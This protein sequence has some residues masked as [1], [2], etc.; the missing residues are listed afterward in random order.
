MCE[1]ELCP[2]FYSLL[3]SGRATR[4]DQIDNICVLSGVDS[5]PLVA[6][7]ISIIDLGSMKCVKGNFFLSFISLLSSGRATRSDQI[8]NIR[9]VLSGVDSIPLV[10]SAISIISF[11]SM[12]C[13]ISNR[14][15][16][17]NSLP[18]DSA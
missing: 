15:L 10:A 5:I 6:S 11:G 8:D 2:L 1:R 3:S 16:L 9:C 4:S 7:V 14:L 18:S 12:K 17:V 13:V